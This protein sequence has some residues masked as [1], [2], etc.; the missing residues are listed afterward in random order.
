MRLTNILTLNKTQGHFLHITVKSE[1]HSLLTCGKWN[2][3]YVWEGVVSTAC[4]S[5]SSSAIPSAFQMN[6]GALPH[7]HSCMHTLYMNAET[8]PVAT[9]SK[10]LGSRGP[11]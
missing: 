8:S 10:A 6:P 9:V 4:P 1:E 5:G 7:L 11:T 3:L 2:I